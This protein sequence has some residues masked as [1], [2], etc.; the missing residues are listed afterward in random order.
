MR[1]ASVLPSR[2][3]LV[4]SAMLLASAPP[5][6]AQTVGDCLLGTAEADLDINDV[7]ARLFNS[8]NLF[9]GNETTSGDGYLVPK[10]SRN[11]P[12]FA[13]NL[14]VGGKVDGEI[15]T[16]A[17]RYQNFE[18][19]PGPLD[20]EGSPPADCSAFDRIYLVSRG[21]VARYLD[22]GE[23]TDDLRDWPVDLG[24][25]VLDGDGVAGNYDLAGGDEPALSGEQM[26]WWVMNDAG[27]R[28]PAFFDSPPI[29][30]EARVSAFAVPSTTAALH[31]A[32]LYRYRFTHRGS[33]PLDSAYVTFWTDSDLGDASDDF[34][35]SDT[36]LSM[37][38][39]YNASEP[40]AF[41]GVPPAVGIKVIQ[42]PVGLPNGRDDDGDSEVDEPDERL[43]MTASPCFSKLYIGEP[44]TPEGF[45]NCMRG[46][47][48]D[49]TP[50]TRWGG[51][52]GS[53]FPVTTF[54]DPG[55]PIVGAFWSEEN[56]DG[57]GVRNPSGD[58]RFVVVTGPFRLAPGASTE[59]VFVIPFAQGADRLDSIVELREAARY[60]QN[61]YEVGFFEPQ[62]VGG[63]PEPVLP[64]AFGLSRPFPN[65]FRSATSLTLTVP[66]GAGRA[67]LSVFDVLG[68]EVAVLADGLLPPGEQTLT[69][70]GAGLPAGVYLVRLRTARQ[71]ETLK[72]LHVE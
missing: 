35:G 1:F 66:E 13:S 54:G 46:L 60:L 57:T 12:I 51:G 19:W 49:G 16:A 23:A 5:A 56:P 30:L 33:A 61:A 71:T 43:G 25:P 18:F 44:I 11:S 8:G 26:A 62:R 55:D 67:R 41:Y 52:Y 17:G 53:D 24:A 28:Y 22:T 7:S 40:D 36:T 3:G 72:V 58:R 39:T 69:L 4:L 29:G 27:N 9:F 47:W 59:V 6:S 70:G 37:G 48:T 32:T 38:F 34:I 64:D 63:V 20:E 50:I 42:G 10:A 15:R 2:V 65:P 45:Y 31:Q 68:R 21:D 14:W